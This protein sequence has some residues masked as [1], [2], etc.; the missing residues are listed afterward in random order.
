MARKFEVY[1]SGTGWLCA[2]PR[3]ADDY[4]EYGTWVPVVQLTPE[5]CKE[6]REFLGPSVDQIVK[7]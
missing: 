3:E 5:Q 4:N 2:K 7:D 6:I 1:V